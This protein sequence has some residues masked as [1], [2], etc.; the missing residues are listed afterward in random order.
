[1]LLQRSQWIKFKSGQG[2]EAA[3]ITNST[4]RRGNAVLV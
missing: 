1:M 4:A 3:D 2:D